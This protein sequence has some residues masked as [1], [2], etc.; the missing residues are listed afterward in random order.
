MPRVGRKMKGGA[1]DTVTIGEQQYKISSE[2]KGDETVICV[3]VGKPKAPKEETQEVNSAAAAT[4]NDVN[5]AEAEVDGQE[6]DGGKRRRRRNTAKKGGK[7]AKKGGK[8]GG[9]RK[10]GGRKGGKR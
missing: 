7:S 2:D 1:E 9:T 3:S 10:R 8:T 5:T 4:L 6:V